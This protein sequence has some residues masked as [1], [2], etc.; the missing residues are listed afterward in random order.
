MTR[1]YIAKEEKRLR[2]AELVRRLS[3]QPAKRSPPVPA[4]MQRG[5]AA[6]GM[7]K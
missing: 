5:H 2:N 7:A 3:T 4:V 6:T 1:E